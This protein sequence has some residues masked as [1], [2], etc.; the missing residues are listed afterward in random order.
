MVVFANLAAPVKD[1]PEPPQRIDM[2]SGRTW[3]LPQVSY[4]IHTYWYRVSWRTPNGTW[5]VHQAG[6]P[7]SL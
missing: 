2:G 7:W 6:G 1:E 4:D 5:K 3:A